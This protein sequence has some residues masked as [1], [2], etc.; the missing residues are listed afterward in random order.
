MY[1]AKPNKGLPAPISYAALALGLLIL[2]GNEVRSVV[3]SASL[4]APARPIVTVD[5]GAVDPGHD[6]ATVHVTGL[7]TARQLAADPR[8][9]V[10]G[11]FLLLHRIV[12]M[13]QWQKEPRRGPVNVSGVAANGFDLRWSAQEVDTRA[14]AAPHEQQNPPMPV[15]SESFAAEGLHL[16]AFTLPLD[17]LTAFG[18]P[19]KLR[20]TRELAA[21]L[22]AGFPDA[23]G[24]IDRDW[25]ILATEPAMASPRRSAQARAVWPAGTLRVRFEVVP[26][27]TYSVV[28]RQS[29]SSLLPFDGA[30]G[31]RQILARPGVHP[32][33]A[34]YRQ[35]RGKNAFLT[36]ALRLLGIGLTVAGLLG[37]L[38]HRSN[39]RRWGRDYAGNDWSTGDD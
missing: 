2:I 21:A 37:V 36:W 19:E 22:A 5:P 33:E 17:A 38:T 35:A 4:S 1:R 32:V 7:V 3:A 29:Q 10:S 34:I 30:M 18:K 15:R 6:G 39:V 25:V 12:E 26:A 11:Q 28:A 20:P 31:T 9:P 24:V 13:Q 14:D 27:G 23:Q 8:F 16:G